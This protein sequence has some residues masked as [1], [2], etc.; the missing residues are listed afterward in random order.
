M[1]ETMQDEALHVKY[2]KVG[3]EP[4]VADVQLDDRKTTIQELMMEHFKDEK[5]G[6]FAYELFKLLKEDK[7]DE[8]LELSDKELKKDGNRP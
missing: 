2:E 4:A 1:L 5:N 6:K 8:A 7:I 3:Q